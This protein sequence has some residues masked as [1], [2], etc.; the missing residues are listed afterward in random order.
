MQC[1]S[2]GRRKRGFETGMHTFSAREVGR[3][4]ELPSLGKSGI[5]SKFVENQPLWRN[6]K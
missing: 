1:V 2:T 5:L 3:V 6:A 4:L